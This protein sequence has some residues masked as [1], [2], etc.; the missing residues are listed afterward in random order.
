MTAAPI[1]T[2]A[3]SRMS[4]IGRSRISMCGTPVLAK[5]EGKQEK[6]PRPGTLSRVCFI[7]LTDNC[8]PPP[9]LN[10]ISNKTACI[11]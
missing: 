1:A 7:M 10:K 5:V 4:K 3:K 2:A 6:G 9:P 11:E 8:S